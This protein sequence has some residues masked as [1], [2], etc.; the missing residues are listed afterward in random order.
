M[1]RAGSTAIVD[2]T[3]EPIHTVKAT[4]NV[5]SYFMF[6]TPTEQKKEGVTFT[7]DVMMAY[8]LVIMSF[9]FQGILL[10]PSL[11]RSLSRT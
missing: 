7:T 8:F 2:D 6:I 3:E 5:Y 10:I 11:T 9:F 1:P 4:D